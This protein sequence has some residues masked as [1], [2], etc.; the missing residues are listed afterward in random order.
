MQ[1]IR[2]YLFGLFTFC[3][4][5]AGIGIPVYLHYCGGELEEVSYLTKTNSCCGEE[6]TEDSDCC[7]NE[8]HVLRSALDARLTPEER[9]AAEPTL[10]LSINLCS[11]SFPLDSY[12]IVEHIRP[13]VSPPNFQQAQIISTRCLRI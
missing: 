2:K 8:S 13:S 10:L 9:L 5:M 7:H 1:N 4:V 6:E 12:T 11:V 3:Y